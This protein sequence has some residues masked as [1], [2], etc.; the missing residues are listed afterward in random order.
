MTD[1][2]E[3]IVKIGEVFRIYVPGPKLTV[4]DPAGFIGGHAFEAIVGHDGKLRI[5]SEHHEP[6]TTKPEDLT[7]KS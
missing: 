3:T 2:K 5:L 6:L 7:K 1:Y 4:A